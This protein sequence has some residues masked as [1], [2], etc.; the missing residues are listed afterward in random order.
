MRVTPERAR[1]LCALPPLPPFMR[2]QALLFHASGPVIENAVCRLLTSVTRGRSL[3]FKVRGDI[4]SG[5]ELYDAAC[6]PRV[7]PPALFKT[8]ILM[9]N[10]GTS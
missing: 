7:L 10:H 1:M 6:G 9:G 2:N 8:S 4:Q 3:H 5:S